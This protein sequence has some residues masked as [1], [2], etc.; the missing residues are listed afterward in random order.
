MHPINKL[1]RENDDKNLYLRF[2]PTKMSQVYVV[3]VE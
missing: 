1:K 3:V 2:E